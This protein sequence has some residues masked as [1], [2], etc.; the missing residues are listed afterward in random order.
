[1]LTN[2]DHPLT[3][4]SSVITVCTR[5]VPCSHGSVMPTEPG[6]KK[7]AA[8]SCRHRLGRNIKVMNQIDIIL[9]RQK[10]HTKGIS[11]MCITNEK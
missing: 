9:H 4:C 8:N 6:R 2:Y 5:I 1:M 11:G 10:V 3:C 7:P